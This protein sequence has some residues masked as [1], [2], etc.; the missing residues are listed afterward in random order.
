[1]NNNENKII[2]IIKQINEANKKLHNYEHP[3]LNITFEDLYK[4]INNSPISNIENFTK[5]KQNE[6]ANLLELISEFRK[7][8]QEESELLTNEQKREYYTQFTNALKYEA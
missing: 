2:A 5:I 4:V 3:L 8:M 1:M 6:R 7:I